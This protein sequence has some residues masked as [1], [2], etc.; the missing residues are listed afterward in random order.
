MRKSYLKLNKNIDE[1]NTILKNYQTGMKDGG[2]DT[3]DIYKSLYKMM[4]EVDYMIH[5]KYVEFSKVK[6]FIQGWWI[7]EVAGDWIEA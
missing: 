6:E 2:F 1:I 7:K 3:D 4:N 5:K